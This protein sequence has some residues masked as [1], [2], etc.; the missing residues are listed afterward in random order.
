MASVDPGLPN[1]WAHLKFGQVGFP[2]GLYER[3]SL[4]AMAAMATALVPVTFVW[5]YIATRCALQGSW[6]SWKSQF[7]MRLAKN[8]LFAAALT[9]PPGRYRYHFVVNGR[10]GCCIQQLPT[11][12]DPVHGQCNVIEVTLRADGPA[13][14]HRVTYPSM[15]DTPV[16]Q[17]NSDSTLSPV[18]SKSHAKP[19]AATRTTINST[20]HSITTFRGG[21]AARVLACTEIALRYCKGDL[22]A[23]RSVACLVFGSKLLA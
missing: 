19:V 22:P 5:P 11:E 17:S 10:Q 9:L 15:L 23:S 1:H 20:P 18:K 16:Q 13:Q 2:S 21:P 12:A 14:Q 7:P 3:R 4:A 6:D 8:G